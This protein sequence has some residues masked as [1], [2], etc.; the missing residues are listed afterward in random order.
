MVKKLFWVIAIF[1]MLFFIAGCTAKNRDNTEP[2]HA[3]ADFKMYLE[4]V[5]FDFNKAKYMSTPYKHLSEKVHMHDFNPDV[6]HFHD[7]NAALRDF[8]TSV[9]MIITQNCLDTGEDAYCTDT[10]KSLS[11]Y[12]NG[13]KE[14]RLFNYVPNDLDKLLIYYGPGEPGDWMFS[15]IT[16]QACIYSL[17]C[18]P[19]PGFELPDESCSA[20]EPCI[21]DATQFDVNSG[22]NTGFN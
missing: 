5:Q 19:P 21:L 11:L 13:K 17:K 10:E 14:A 4:G 18:E 9:G 2:Y 7:E 8:F 6:I 16:G 20:S 1:A 22:T 15:G 12:V 3:H